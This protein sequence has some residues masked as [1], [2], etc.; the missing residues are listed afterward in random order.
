MY[1]N[2]NTGEVWKLDHVEEIPNNP[3]PIIVY[4]FENGDRWNEELFF[5]HFFK[6]GEPSS[7]DTE[8]NIT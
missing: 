8:R 2:K 7:L 3:K 4:V 5:K 1:K 6:V